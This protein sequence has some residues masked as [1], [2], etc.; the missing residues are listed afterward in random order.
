MINR[1]Q[2]YAS[3]RGLV[4]AQRPETESLC[5]YSRFLP[6]RCDSE[7]VSDLSRSV[8]VS[9]YATRMEPMV[10]VYMKKVKGTESIR[11]EVLDKRDKSCR[12]L[13]ASS[14]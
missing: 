1:V 4:T 10:C 6:I 5:A 12:N 8:G 7:S 14:C 2:G 3:C 13:V 11:F 9:V